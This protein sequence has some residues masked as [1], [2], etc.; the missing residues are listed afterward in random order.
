LEASRCVAANGDRRP[1]KEV[2]INNFYKI[3]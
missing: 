2:L 3:G 1:A